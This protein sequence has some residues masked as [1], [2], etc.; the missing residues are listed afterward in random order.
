MYSKLSFSREELCSVM[1]QAYDALIDFVTTMEFGQVYEELQELAPHERPG[2]VVSVLL[3]PDELA[4]RGIRVPERILIQRSAFGGRRPTLF[5]VKKLL[6][7]K[8]SNV[9]QNVNITFDNEFADDSVSRV[10]EI[11]WRPPLAVDYQ[12]QAMASGKDLQTL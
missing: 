12:A 6:P 8:Y 7:A 1:R 5:C 4:R 3:N 10:P 9:W 2:F 11:A